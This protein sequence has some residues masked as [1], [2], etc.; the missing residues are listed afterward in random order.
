MILR[1]K[2]IM[3]AFLLFFICLP[4]F[5]N[6]FLY[7]AQVKSFDVEFLQGALLR[8]NAALYIQDGEFK[9]DVKDKR[10]FCQIDSAKFS[11]IGDVLGEKEFTI[12][13]TYSSKKKSI[14]ISGGTNEQLSR[15]FDII[16]SR[17]FR[18]T[19]AETNNVFHL[20]DDLSMQTKQAQLNLEDRIDT[21]P[22]N[23]YRRKLE[24]SLQKIKSHVAA[25]NVLEQSPDESVFEIQLSNLLSSP[26]VFK[27]TCHFKSSDQ[28]KVK[29]LK[30]LL[31]G[32]L[33]LNEIQSRK[34]QGLIQSYR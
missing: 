5:A 23:A 30:K 14:Q 20:L 19:V 29:D 13:D 11:P 12:G 10:S 18:F 17:Q 34:H 7:L 1:H 16:G 28:L 15:Y 31:A 24:E 21:L 3:R 6:D 33:K 22:N 25:I 8:E 32:V 26:R 4:V 2:V 9:D 27:M